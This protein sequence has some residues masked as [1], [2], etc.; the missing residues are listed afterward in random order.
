M[1]DEDK[2]YLLCGHS[3]RLAMDFGLINK[4]TRTIIILFEFPK[5]FVCVVIATLPTNSSLWLL[6]G[7]LSLVMDIEAL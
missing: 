5:A 1:D 7:K 6:K 4:C 2:E 3:E